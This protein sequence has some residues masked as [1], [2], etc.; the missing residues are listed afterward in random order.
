MAEP[1][2]EF[3]PVQF[4]AIQDALSKKAP[5]GGACP[6]CSTNDWQIGS[7]LV[8][9]PVAPV[10]G[11]TMLGAGASLPSIPLICKNCGNTVLLNAFFL[12]VGDVLGLKQEAPPSQQEKTG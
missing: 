9:V 5:L 8:I 11:L 3:T 6:I 2:A 12:G 1:T 10:A 7:R 4:A